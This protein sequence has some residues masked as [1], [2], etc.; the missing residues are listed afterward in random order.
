MSGVSEE[1][2]EVIGRQAYRGPGFAPGGR[3]GK[4]GAVIE[5]RDGVPGLNGTT[6]ETYEEF[7]PF[8]LSQHLHP[9]TQKVHAAGT[10]TA[11]GV[12]VTA[13][14]RGRWKAF[15]ASPLFAYGPAFAS[16][17]IWEKNRPVVLGGSFWWAARADLE[18]VSK[19]ITGRIGRDAAAVREALGFRPEERTIADHERLRPVAA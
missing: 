3:S 11:I 18:L 14:L 9:T 12:G 1:G 15:L 17:F 19:V 13:L 5:F 7:W 8:Y 10:L 2:A 6:P 16:H 4:G